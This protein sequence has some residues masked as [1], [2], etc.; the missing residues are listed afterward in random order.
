MDRA[1]STDPSAEPLLTRLDLRGAEDPTSALPA[2][3][4][5]AELPVEAVRGIIADVRARGDEALLELT[6]RFDGVRPDSLRVGR[7]E[8]EAAVAGLEP[9]VLAALELAATRVRVHHEAQMQPAVTHSGDGVVVTS[10]RRPVASAGC[11]V[12]GGRAAYPSTLLMTAVV[13]R[14]AGVERVVVCVPPDSDTGRVSPVTLAAASVAGVDEVYAV[15]GAQAVAAMAYGTETIDAVD[16]VCGPGN[17]YVA[18][19]KQQVAGDVGVAAAFAGPSEVVV[20]ADDSVPPEL[21][22]VDLML[23]AEHG[24]DGLA[25]LVTWDP[26]VIDAVEAALAGLLPA[27]ERRSEIESTLARSGWSVLVDSPRAAIRVTDGVAPEHLELMCEGAS[28]LA[29]Q[30]RNAGAVF[31]GQWSPASLGDYTAGPSHV[32]PTHR[33]A[34][35][36]EALGVEDFTKHVHVV[37]A[38]AEGIETLGP[39]TATLASAEGLGAH[40]ESVLM[41]L[42]MLDGGGT[43]TDDPGNGRAAAGGS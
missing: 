42:R 7:E 35:F 8:M 2:P 39:P 30:V 17:L 19:A 15:G 36:A 1:Q 43:G 22:A 25:W 16:V 34:R 12:P 23:Q 18:V 38:S 27:A 24:P 20:V 9:E 3:D 31:C 11:Y 21:V 4:T 37:T 6:E 29:E 33:S 10:T 41:R 28:D 14:V 40:A 13:A 32:L 5:A 26:G